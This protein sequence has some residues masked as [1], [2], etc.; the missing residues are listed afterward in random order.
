VPFREL[1]V[2]IPNQAGQLARLTEVLAAA[3]VNLL[4]LA[5]SSDGRNG[6]VR[7]AVDHH[8]LAEDAL[9]NAGYEVEAQDALGVLLPNQPGELHKVLKTLFDNSLSIDY[10]YNCS[11]QDAGRL[12]TIIGVTSPRKAG[13]ILR[14][15]GIDVISEDAS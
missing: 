11:H 9:H 14:A 3:G 10:I 4:G 8:Q 6:W 2:E 12:L 13:G 1:C 5:A 7:L 15:V